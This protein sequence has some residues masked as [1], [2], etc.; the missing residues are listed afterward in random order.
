[1]KFAI[2][3][4]SGRALRKAGAAVLKNGG[5]CRGF[6]LI[7]VMV[8]VIII[9]ILATLAYSSLT[10]MIFTNRAKETAQ[11]MRTFAERALSDSKRLN[12]V[13]TIAIT[14]NKTMQYTPDGGTTV[15]EPLGNFSNSSTVPT[16]GNG[17]N[18][19]D[20][21]SFN[22]GAVS[23]LKVGI[24]GIALAGNGNSAKTQG[25]FV[26]CDAKGYCSATVKVNAKNSFVACIKRPKN[27][28]W[29]TL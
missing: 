23:Q 28:N 6:T 17:P 4:T 7:E 27:T 10:E 15:T 18:P 21:V 25:Y 2:Y 8:V 9:G 20:Y 3:K 12:K 1:M 5:I 26:A 24:S 14:N 19:S 29:E 13:V 16:C 11:L 22:N